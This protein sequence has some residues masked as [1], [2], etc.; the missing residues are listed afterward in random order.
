ML[1]V[2][3]KCLTYKLGAYYPGI[4][5]E[6]GENGAMDN[7]A[8]FG[9]IKHSTLTQMQGMFETVFGIITR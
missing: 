6:G 1:L 7:E 4:E 9:A 3:W 8:S 2:A 5:N